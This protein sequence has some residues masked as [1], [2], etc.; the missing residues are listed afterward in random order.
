MERGRRARP[1]RNATGAATKDPAGG[2]KRERRQE[3]TRNRQIRA[4]PLL[5]RC[6]LAQQD[7]HLQQ[8]VGA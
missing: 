1:V 6:L 2:D 4:G 3:R 5:A 7:L 8:G